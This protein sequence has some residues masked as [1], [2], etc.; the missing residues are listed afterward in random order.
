MAVSKYKLYQVNKLKR[1]HL[2]SRI[3]VKY[4]VY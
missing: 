4:D 1:I 2:L 3:S